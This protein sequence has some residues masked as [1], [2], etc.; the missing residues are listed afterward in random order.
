MVRIYLLVEISVI[1][2]K[3]KG[4]KSLNYD[5]FQ[6]EQE[7]HIQCPSWTYQ[8]QSNCRCG[9]YLHGI[10]DC[11]QATKEVKL[12]K[13]YCMTHSDIAMNTTVVGSCIFNCAVDSSLKEYY[14]VT[15]DIE[16]LD[17]EICGQYNR[18]GQMCSRCR[19][20]YGIVAYSY[21]HI[22]TNCSEYRN[23]WIKYIAVALVPLTLFYAAMLILNRNCIFNGYILFSQIFTSPIVTILYEVRNNNSAYLHG[24]I[25]LYGVWNLD[26][27]RSLYKSFC[28][29]PN[30]TIHQAVA[31]DYLIA[32]YPL[33]LILITYS[34]VKLHDNYKLAVIIW[35]PFYFCTKYIRKEW[36]IK[37]S[38]L[39]L[40]AMFLLLSNVKVLSVS[41]ALISTPVIL[42]DMHNRPLPLKYTYLNGSMEYLGKEHIPYFI[43]G[44]IFILVFN[45]L[46][47]LLFCL[48]PFRWF[49]RCLN[50]CSLNS[51]SLRIFMDAF[52]GC[53]KITPYDCRRFSALHLITRLVNFIVFYS[54]LNQSYF[55]LMA[56][57]TAALSFLILTVR[58]YTSVAQN[59]MEGLAY[60]VIAVIFFVMN[61]AKEL[62]HPSY[63]ST[64]FFLKSS[65]PLVP[66]LAVVVW[67]SHQLTTRINFKLL[68]PILK[69]LQ[70][71]E[72]KKRESTPLLSTY[73][74]I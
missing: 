21:D 7:S 67:A 49:Q 3:I 39:D 8:N 9:S 65:I 46:P 63:K 35:K 47:I 64:Y 26:F 2:S 13:C 1:L 53:Y 28:L 62:V 40:F 50:S 19:E 30:L 16:S 38:L 37:A 20:G 29:H 61:A 23:N 42:V 15:K 59:N 12:L 69:N 55:T 17:N 18:E 10:V 27:G 60:L 58:P 72:T 43:L 33:L 5:F 51:P 70:A 34:Y 54:T 56:I 68:K 14:R 25:T 73:Q 66:T 11:N 41:F 36:N 24:L 22:C 31:L 57:I 45:I 44:M 32:L 48:Y 71:I 6:S 74:E 52:Q 4:I